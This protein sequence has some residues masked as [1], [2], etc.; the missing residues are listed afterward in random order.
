MGKFKTTTQQQIDFINE[1]APL[2]QNAYKILGKVKPSV[3]IGMACVESGFGWGSDGTRLMY[4]HNA[5][6]GQKVG[7]GKT[8]TKYWSGKSFNA[9][10][11]E[12]YVIGVHTNIQANFRAYDNLAQ[13]ILN[14]YEL[15]NTNF[16]KRVVAN[17][18]Y[19]TQMRQIKECGYMTSSTEVNSVLKIINQFNLTQ[20][21]DVAFINPL[22]VK[23]VQAENGYVIGKTY[24]TDA[25]L[26]IRVSPNG[27]KIEPKSLT[28][29]AQINAYTDDEGYSI[30][31]KGT[32]VTCKGIKVVNNSTWMQIPSGWICAIQN[33]KKY[34]I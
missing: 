2:A 9:K 16:Y 29:N 27:D 6:L 13:C 18:D 8:A 33:N 1:I 30:L 28:S 21:D 24:T 12:E 19:A 34:I 3:C 14:Y 4:K 20:F 11:S 31:R 22:V 7:S 32:K 5:V 25:N 10:T 17:V 26:Y 23:E 15:L